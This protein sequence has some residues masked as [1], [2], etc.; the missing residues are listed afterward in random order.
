MRVDGIYVNE[1]FESIQGEGALYGYRT[2]FVRLQGCKKG[3]SFCDSKDTWKKDEGHKIK[4]IDLYNTIKELISINYWLCFTG[5]EPLEQVTPLIWLLD[6]LCK[7]GYKKLSIETSGDI[8]IDQKDILDL[9]NL[10]I[11]FSVSPKLFSALKN[12]FDY[13]Y[14]LDKCK[15]WDLHVNVSYKLQFKFVVS[16]SEDLEIIKKLYSDFK[17]DHHVF[18]Q[19][20]HSKVSDINFVKD[21]L[22]IQK[23]NNFEKVR[24]S[25]QQHKFLGLK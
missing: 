19:I 14:L 15:L 8:E 20:E 6:K 9:A 18:L 24:I 4:V 2:L 17:T 22:E 3:C 7:A 11:F 23:L 1:I 16:C 25:S 10:N 12:R 5:G 21:C 13:N